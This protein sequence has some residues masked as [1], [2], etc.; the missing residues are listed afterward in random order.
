MSA[1]SHCP[2]AD[3]T[4]AADLQ[5]RQTAWDAAAMFPLGAQTHA[6]FCPLEAVQICRIAPVYLNLISQSLP[7]LYV[8]ALTKNVP[9]ACHPAETFLLVQLRAHAPPR[10]P[11]D[12][13]DPNGDEMAASPP[14]NETACRPPPVFR[15]PDETAFHHADAPLEE[16]RLPARSESRAS[17]PAENPNHRPL[18]VPGEQNRPPALQVETAS[19]L[20]AAARH[21]QIVSVVYPLEKLAAGRSAYLA[22]N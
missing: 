21:C 3:E 17:W 14:A 6:E 1:V 10:E 2:S 18:A 15:Q 12:P 4:R 16:H 20:R 19:P 9:R 7:C 8:A 5:R 11:D 22:E 13:G